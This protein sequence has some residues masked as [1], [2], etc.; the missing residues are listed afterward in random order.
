MQS[1]RPGYPGRW[2]PK[3]GLMYPGNQYLVIDWFV[4]CS[5]TNHPLMSKDIFNKALKRFQQEYASSA[6]RQ[7]DPFLSHIKDSI[8]E[9][10][11]V[12]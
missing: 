7:N 9:R 2:G 5:H 1:L 12:C 8:Y 11:M 3:P 10:T 4:F 6:V